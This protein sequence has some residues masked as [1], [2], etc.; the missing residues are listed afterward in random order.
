MKKEFAL[1]II[2]FL[3]IAYLPVKADE[4]V[5]R[6][7]GKSDYELDYYKSSSLPLI[8]GIEAGIN[9][10]FFSQSINWNPDYRIFSIYDCMTKGSAISPHFGIL[11]DIPINKKLSF[12]ARLSYDRKSFGNSGTGTDTIIGYPTAIN[13]G[14]GWDVTNDYIA[15]AFL[16]RYN[17][18]NYWFV[19]FGPTVHFMTGNVNA[20][21]SG[22]T[23][24]GGPSPD[25]C[26]YY[27][28]VDAIFTET[29]A[30]TM[31]GLELGAGY[32]FPL[33]Q[34]IFLVPQAR[35]QL[36]LSPI[37]NDGSIND[38]YRNVAVVEF[39]KRYSY[40]LQLALALW[41]NI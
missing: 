11:F 23:G 12:Q 31:F 26:N 25:D 13:I 28:F 15:T 2:I 16:L 14:I 27:Q 10:N 18:D 35:F 37:F 19:T 41:F 7:R 4:D 1:I 38:I 39:I 30:Q 5:L 8:F 22:N 34:D 29:K 36:S 24:F 3:F 33:T 20:N 40:S 32:K 17:I 6:P 21:K 9:F